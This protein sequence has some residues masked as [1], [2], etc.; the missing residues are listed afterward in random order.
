MNPNENAGSGGEPIT[1]RDAGVDLRAAE[2]L[3]RR[4]GE[5]VASTRTAAAEGDF[6]SF[7]GRFRLPGASELV[8]SA[9]GVGTKVLVAA[10]AG[11]HDTVGEDLVNHCVNDILAEGAE[12]LFFLDYFACGKLEEDVAFQ[13]IE[14]VARGCRRNGCALLGGETAEMPGMYA[15]GEYDLAGFIVGRRVFDIPGRKG[16]RAGDRLIALPSTGLHTNGY[17]LARKVVFERLGLGVNDLWPGLEGEMVGEA[18]LRVHRS[19]LEPLRGVLEAGDVR[20]L[21]H[22]TGGGI[23]GNLSRVLPAE[24]DAVVDLD[25]W[26]RPALFSLLAEE[27]GLSDSD[28]YETLNMGVGMIVIVPAERSE[29]VLDDSGIRSA[30]GFDCGRIVPGDGTVRLVRSA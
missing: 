11:V 24:C 20:A 23:P 26:S 29:S 13:V 22:I 9:D 30:G 4:L 3:T 1:Y 5:L 14:G 18:L 16:V 15:P 21:A 19:Y 2:S 7:G 27:S 8:A 17:S 10:R 6:G 28:L 25:S 12:P